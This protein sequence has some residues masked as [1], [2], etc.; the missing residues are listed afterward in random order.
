MSGSMALGDF[1]VLAT[2]YAK[3]RPGYSSFIVDAFL[4][5]LGGN[6]G[7]KVADVGAG[8]G[9]FSRAL[10]TRGI[11]VI[12][13]EP[14][15]AMREEGIKQTG[16]LPMEWVKGSAEATTLPD[17]SFDAV[18]MASSF[19]WADFDAA[20]IEFKRI[21]K[22]GGLFMALWNPRQYE[23]DPVLLDIENT[24]RTMVPNLHR[25]S[26]G[27]S[28]FCESLFSRLRENSNIK[29]VLHLEGTHVE[30]QSHEHYLGLWNSVNDIRVQA[31]DE[32]FKKFLGVVK[33]KI[34]HLP[35]VTAE[36]RTRA[37]I[38]RF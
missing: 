12:A 25:V 21:L 17:A 35:F 4:G 14:N 30:Q 9:I 32:V 36:Y 11:P 3:Y 31:G 24:L 20:L 23:V 6:E 15:D 27:R 38:A 16:A 5:L 26:S 29:D 7:V 37:W 2:D 34:S 28:D 8:T 1:T 18:C 33:E 19:H 10:A 22:P 13:I